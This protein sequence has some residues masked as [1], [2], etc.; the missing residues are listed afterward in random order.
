M[1]SLKWSIRGENKGERSLAS[2]GAWSV[3]RLY[4]RIRENSIP[5]NATFGLPINDNGLEIAHLN[6][7]KS[8]VLCVCGT[9]SH[10]D[11]TTDKTKR[12]LRRLVV[13]GGGIQEGDSKLGQM[14]AKSILVSRVAECGV[15]SLTPVSHNG[16]HVF[17]FREFLFRRI[18][19]CVY[20][21]LLVLITMPRKMPLVV[22]YSQTWI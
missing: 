17:I 3:V 12:T 8:S 20:T 4:N 16:L 6:K 19:D 22:T 13:V 5:A 15:T 2:W 1:D 11:E 18:H 14:R 7:T 21:Q 10:R 9:W